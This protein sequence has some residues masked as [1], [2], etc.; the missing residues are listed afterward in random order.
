VEQPERPASRSLKAVLAGGSALGPE[1]I[2]SFET[3][4]G[5]P[6]RQVYGMTEMTSLT[7]VE[8]RDLDPGDART[9]GPPVPFARVCIVDLDGKRLPAGA[10]GEILLSGPS[11]FTRYEGEP[12]LTAGKL[13]DGW[14]RSGDLGH[15]DEH[16][17]LSIVDRID[18]MVIVSGE[19]VYPAEIENLVPR[20]AGIQDAVVVALPHAVTGVDLVLVHTLLPGAAAD[21]DAWRMTLMEHLSKFKVPRR[22]V[23]LEEIGVDA[24]PR[25]PVG[26]IQRSEVQRLAVARLA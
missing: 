7:T 9:A 18:S 2:H 20:L 10:D 3:T 4:F 25:T 8:E 15:V 26:K 19:N 13:V 17:R 6:V 21:H 16:G 22:F 12:G 23:A 1:L 5:I 24:F 14:V 11:I